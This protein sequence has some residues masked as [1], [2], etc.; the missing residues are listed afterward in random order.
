MSGFNAG[1]AAEMR[2]HPAVGADVVGHVPALRALVPVIRA[3]HE[4]W[5]GQDY[6]DVLAGEAIPLGARIIGVADAYG[7]ITGDRPYRHARTEDWAIGE[8]QRCAGTQFDPTVVAALEQV[9]AT[10]SRTADH[11]PAPSA[12]SSAA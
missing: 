1:K 8:L 12:P 9:L 4:R 11:L 5:D 2:A 6:P 10:S 7:A 3:H